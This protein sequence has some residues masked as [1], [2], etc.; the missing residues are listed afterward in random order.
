METIPA[1]DDREDGSIYT[2]RERPRCDLRHNVGERPAENSA[3]T[4][5][6]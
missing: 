1:P 2:G 3:C 4:P 6:S 5:P